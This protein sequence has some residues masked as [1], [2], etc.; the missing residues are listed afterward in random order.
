MLIFFFLTLLGK[1]LFIFIWGIIPHLSH[2]KGNASTSC[3]LPPLSLLRFLLCHF[4]LIFFLFSLCL[5][6]LFF[7]SPLAPYF[8][9][10]YQHHQSF[11]T[12]PAALSPHI[13]CLS[14][15]QVQGWCNMMQ[16]E[17]QASSSREQPNDNWGP[18]TA[19]SCHPNPP[20]PRLSNP[21][22]EPLSACSKQV[23]RGSRGM[24]ALLF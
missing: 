17:I 11:L 19:T 2:A 21:H 4:K 9:N 6:A 5:S 12:W 23:G 8:G 3:F 16:P 18:H 24:H 20:L 7:I 22:S 15:R 10:S 1:F 14:E 13:S